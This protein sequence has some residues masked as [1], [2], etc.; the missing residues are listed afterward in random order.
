M[1][2]LVFRVVLRDNSRGIA[3]TNNDGRALRSSLDGRV[4]KGRG[5]LGELGELEDTR[6]ARV[7]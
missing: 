1:A 2:E 3:T 4:E 5:A 6:G 7:A